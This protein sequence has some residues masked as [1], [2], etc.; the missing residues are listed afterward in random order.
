MEYYN[1]FFIKVVIKLIVEY[2]VLVVKKG[3]YLENFKFLI[4]G[5]WIGGDRDGNFF[6]IVEILRLLVMV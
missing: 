3:I 6:V 2:K 5:M 1:C 4:M